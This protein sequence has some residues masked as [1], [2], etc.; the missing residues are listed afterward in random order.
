MLL[1]RLIEVSL[2]FP[3]LSD[4]CADTLIICN[5]RLHLFIGIKSSFNAL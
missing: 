5:E 2:F 4:L 3:W 1:S